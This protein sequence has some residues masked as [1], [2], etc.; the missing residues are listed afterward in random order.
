MKMCFVNL[1]SK[2]IFLILIL[3]PLTSGPII[4]LYSFESCV[5]KV[6]KEKG[7][8]VC[9]RKTAWMVTKIATE[10][11]SVSFNTPNS[12]LYCRTQVVHEIFDA[13]HQAYTVVCPTAGT[14]EIVLILACPSSC[15][16]TMFIHTPWKNTVPLIHVFHTGYRTLVS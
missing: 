15:M 2:N 4:I 3:L 5:E 1:I 7:E 11:A 14:V 16:V 9:K 6:H 8:S 12:H 13:R 10:I